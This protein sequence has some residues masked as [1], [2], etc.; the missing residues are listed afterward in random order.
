[1]ANYL[2]AFF[3]SMEQIIDYNLAFSWNILHSKTVALYRVLKTPSFVLFQNNVGN[4][5]GLLEMILLMA[6]QMSIILTMPTAH[7]LISIYVVW[8]MPLCRVN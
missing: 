8:Q 2:R 6:T 5:K 4:F 1:M 7:G 3:L